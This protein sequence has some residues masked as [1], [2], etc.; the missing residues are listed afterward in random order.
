M[1]PTHNQ[2]IK[3]PF[4]LLAAGILALCLSVPGQGLAAEAAFG[5]EN[6]PTDQ[7]IDYGDI[8]SCSLGTLTD[9]DVFRWNAVAGEMVWI[10]AR[11]LSG[12]EPC[13]IVYD[14]TGSPIGG[15][16]CSAHNQV[17][18]TES[19]SVTQSGTHT[20]VLSDYASDEIGDY[21][22][23]LERL[24]PSSPTAKPIAGFG[25]FERDQFDVLADPDFFLFESFGDETINME[26]KSL[27]GGVEACLFLYD[28][29]GALIAN[30]ACSA[31]NQYTQVI[32]NTLLTV[33]GTY[34]IWLREYASD[35][36]GSYELVVNCLFGT[37][38]E[39]GSPHNVVDIG[40]VMDFDGTAADEMAALVLDRVVQD[41]ATIKDAWSVQIRDM[42]DR[43]WVNAVP[44]GSDST[45][46]GMAVLPDL[47]VASGNGVDEIAVLQ[48]R[49]DGRVLVNIKDASTDAPVAKIFYFTADWEARAITVVEDMNGNGSFEVGVL[50]VD[51][52]TNQARLKV[53]DPETGALLVNKV[54]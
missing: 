43:S 50:A 31:H 11:S 42:G 49:P 1:T 54:P 35:E 28:P 37:C 30:S 16:Q 40:I 21:H 23:I 5:C 9:S 51:R 53:K 14:N 41:D 20:L 46:V 45:I 6:E 24:Q 13:F 39:Q 32:G 2:Q 52:N 34:M 19:F 22:V 44:F 10:V 33:P 12:V 27:S 3:A 17:V 29:A 15:S 25:L 38:L 26:S 18:Q 4:A 36:V 7:A 48:V 47:P 8:I